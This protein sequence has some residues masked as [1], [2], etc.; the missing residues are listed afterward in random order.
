MFEAI[1]TV[2]AQVI[3]LWDD[4]DALVSDAVRIEDTF[5]DE[6]RLREAPQSSS[7]LLAGENRVLLH[8]LQC[9]VIVL[10]LQV[11]EV[12]L[13][14]VG[15][16][17]HITHAKLALLLAY[18]HLP[19]LRRIRSELLQM[20]MEF[21][22]LS[23]AHRQELDRVNHG[24]LWCSRSSPTLVLRSRRLRADVEAATRLLKL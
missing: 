10:L 20:P 19:V 12:D 1:S 16:Q 3:H 17:D 2:L 15:N 5:V 9:I 18:L 8:R 11:G 4:L 7:L 22:R 13:L 24:W 23:R 21:A 6:V 14:S